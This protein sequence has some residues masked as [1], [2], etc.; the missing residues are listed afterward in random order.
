MLPAVENWAKYNFVFWLELKK[1]FPPIGQRQAD[2]VYWILELLAAVHSRCTER[3]LLW[4]MT[5]FPPFPRA[6]GVVHFVLWEKGSCL[7]EA[8]V[9]GLTEAVTLYSDLGA[10]FV[11][12]P[13]LST[14]AGLV[15]PGRLSFLL[16]RVDEGVCGWRRASLLVEISWSGKHTAFLTG[17]WLN[18]KKLV[19]SFTHTW[20][21][22]IKGPP[23]STGH[24]SWFHRRPIRHEHSWESHGKAGLL[25]KKAVQNVLK[26]S[27]N[28]Q[29]CGLRKYY[30]VVFVS[31]MELNY[32]WFKNCTF[33]CFHRT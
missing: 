7:A 14:C 25:N 23:A 31:R 13:A 22:V 19:T 15:W 16:W 10:G 4:V 3:W 11:F 30:L 28:R 20:K 33:S 12:K 2:V 6:T 1:D 24:L 27:C 5:L 26:G 32:S 18:E 21:A 17:Q 8:W 29:V 9:P